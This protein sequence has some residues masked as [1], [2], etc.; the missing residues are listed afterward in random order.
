MILKFA[1]VVP[2]FRLQYETLISAGF[3][4]P[5]EFDER[6]NITVGRTVTEVFLL[7]LCKLLSNITRFIF[8]QR[9]ALNAE[10]TYINLTRYLIPRFYNRYHS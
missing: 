1:Y 2:I 3:H 4:E 10:G 9:Y 6:S 8:A 7:K 5:T